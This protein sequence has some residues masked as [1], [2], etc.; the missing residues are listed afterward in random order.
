[1]VAAIDPVAVD[2]TFLFE[3][4]CATFFDANLI[5]RNGHD[6][7]VAYGFLRSLIRLI[8]KLGRCRIA[9]LLTAETF[10]TTNHGD[11][12][13]ISSILEAI[14]I[15]VHCRPEEDLVTVCNRIRPCVRGLVSVRKTPLQFVSNE[16]VVIRPRSD[17]DDPYLMDAES[18]RKDFGVEPIHTPT[19]LALTTGPRYTRL[20][21]RQTQRLIQTHGDLDKIYGNM[22]ETDK[23]SARLHAFR[24][25]IFERYS[26]YHVTP[27]RPASCGTDA[28][29]TGT[30]TADRLRS[31]GVLKD[32]G[33]HSLARLL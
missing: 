21:V 23:S 20:T 12:D 26:C 11:I 32:I 24:Q 1:M 25:E 30:P 4:S 2:S 31:A 28:L 15:P 8:R 27:E 14:G 3:R 10:S 33:C 29:A 13:Y 19:F 7:T 9:V 6:N 18:V 5:V 16:F 17:H 22:P